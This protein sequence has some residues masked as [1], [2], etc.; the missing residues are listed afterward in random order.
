MQRVLILDMQPASTRLLVDLLKDLGAQAIRGE[1]NVKAAI[2]AAREDEPQLIFTEF[3]GSNWDGLEFVRMVRRSDLNCRQ[4]PVIMVTAE[5]TAQSILG[6]RDAGVHEFLRKPFAIKDLTRRIE[7]V[8]LRSRDW[9]EGV[10]YVGPDRRRF[11]SGDYAG[12]RKRKS[13]APAT[14]HGER[15]DQALRIVR[16]AIGALESDP[17][18]ALRSLDA[19]TV[20]LTQ[21][22]VASSDAK[23]ATAAAF[24]QRQVRACQQGGAINRPGLEAAAQPL[25]DY[26]PAEP[27]SAVA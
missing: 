27:Q 18:Q 2:N 3:A 12:P 22:A 20:D 7:A 16:A 5:A 24:L 17:K 23:L 21:L 13:D 11:N 6:A 14:P 10:R 15:L 8:T 9:I 25:L 26:L 4:A 1:T 19:Q